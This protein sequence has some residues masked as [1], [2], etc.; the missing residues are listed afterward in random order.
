MKNVI[1]TIFYNTIINSCLGLA[2]RRILMEDEIKNKD[3]EIEIIYEKLDVL[4][5]NIDEKYTDKKNLLNELNSLISKELNFMKFMNKFQK[6][7][8]EENILILKFG[9][10]TGIDEKYFIFKDKEYKFLLSAFDSFGMNQEILKEEME[11]VFKEN[12][13]TKTEEEEF[14][15]YLGKYLIESKNKYKFLFSTGDNNYR[16]DEMKSKKAIVVYEILEGKIINLQ[17]KIEEK[18]KK[19]EKKLKTSEN[20]LLSIIGAFVGVF[21]LISIN[22]TFIKESKDLLNPLLKLFVVNLVTVLGIALL[23]FLVSPDIKVNDKICFVFLYIIMLGG[24]IVYFIH[25]QQ[26]LFI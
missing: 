21:T 7:F 13:F 16:I 22:A 18:N 5:N 9:V 25:K 11:K 19:L 23:I 20:Q 14:K 24:L 8:V 10:S 1:L 26:L 15:K 17:K 12:Y 4:I 3:M 2:V 6:Y